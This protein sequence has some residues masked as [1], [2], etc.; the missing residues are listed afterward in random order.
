MLNVQ[1]RLELYYG[2]GAKTRIESS[3]YERTAVEISI[4][5]ERMG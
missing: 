3:P 2:D 1:K 4:A 5:L